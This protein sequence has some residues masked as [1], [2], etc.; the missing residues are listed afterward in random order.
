MVIFHSYVSLP[1]GTDD[2]YMMN[3]MIH[4]MISYVPMMAA[5]FTV[6]SIV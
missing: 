4:H 1:E 5:V 2:T 3:H 6:F